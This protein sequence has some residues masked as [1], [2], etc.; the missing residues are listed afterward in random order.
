MVNYGARIPMKEK[1]WVEKVCHTWENVHCQQ[2]LATKVFFAS[3][4][5][6]WRPTLSEG[7]K[8]TRS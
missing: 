7:T 5:G 4:I 6:C 1:K 2:K 8:K 3:A